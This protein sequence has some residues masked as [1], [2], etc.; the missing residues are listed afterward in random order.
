MNPD[1]IKKQLQKLNDMNAQPLIDKSLSKDE[2]RRM[3]IAIEAKER[4][5]KQRPRWRLEVEPKEM[6]ICMGQADVIH[7]IKGAVKTGKIKTDDPSETGTFEISG[8]FKMRDHYIVDR[9]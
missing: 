7:F 1:D 3:T 4:R 2:V 8:T 9:K 5:Q 6:I